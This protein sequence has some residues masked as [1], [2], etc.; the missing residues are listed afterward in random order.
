MLLFGSIVCASD[1]IA[2]GVVNFLNQQKVTLGTD[3]ALV[4]FDDLDVISYLTPSLTSVWLPKAELGQNAVMQLQAQAHW[5][6][7]WTSNISI[8]G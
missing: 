1:P 2:I 8:L 3:L 4:S 5:P 7:S 6:R